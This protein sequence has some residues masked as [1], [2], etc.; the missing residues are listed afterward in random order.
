MT[1]DPK[2]RPASRPN[3]ILAVALSLACASALPAGQPNDPPATTPTPR[4]APVGSGLA[5]RPNPKLADR[6]PSGA[7]LKPFTNHRKLGAIYHTVAVK[8]F[9]LSAPLAGMQSSPQNLAGYVVARVPMDAASNGALGP[10]IVAGQ[11]QLPWASLVDAATLARWSS[12]QGGPLKLEEFPAVALTIRNAVDTKLISKDESS[13]T[14]MCTIVGDVSL[15]GITTERVIQRALVSFL[16]EVAADPALKGEQLSIR[17]QWMIRLTD[18]F[19]SLPGE[20]SL[21]TVNVNADIVMSTVSP[22]A[23]NGDGDSALM[24]Q[25]SS[26]ASG[27][28][29][30]PKLDPAPPADPPKEPK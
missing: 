29:D 23:Q 6:T 9:T 30:S 15:N 27:E 20:S 16:R 5:R 8:S 2:F 26:P 21:P 18:F 11:W 10:V 4:E 12:A 14:Y 1:T 24:P 22:D 25:D 13:T 19:S 3:A 28:S 17:A 7:A